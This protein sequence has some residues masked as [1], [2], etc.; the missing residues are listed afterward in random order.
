MQH[1]FHHNSSG[2]DVFTGNLLTPENMRATSL[3]PIKKPK[4]LYRMH[5]FFNHRKILDLRQQ[6]F[7][8]E[9]T[10]F[11]L[12]NDLALNTSS[13]EVTPELKALLKSTEPVVNE[14]FL[15]KPSVNDAM[16]PAR[17]QDR[18]DFD[19]FTRSLFASTYISPKRRLEGYWQ[20][21]IFE[22][23]RQIMND[24]NS[25]AIERGRIIDYK[26]WFRNFCSIQ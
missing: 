22:N 25:N 23:L 15:S 24:I 1:I 4:Y 14:R 19:F 6:F 3:H 8:L 16:N 12:K 13:P 20:A 7:N 21:S 10:V 18:H 11:K 26:G 9:R 17:P 2:N 5:N